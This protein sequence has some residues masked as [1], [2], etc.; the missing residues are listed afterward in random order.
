MIDRKEQPGQG[1][2]NRI[3]KLETPGHG[4]E[5][6]DKAPGEETSQDNIQF[7]QQ[8]FK[9]KKVDRDI[10]KKEDKPLDKQD[11]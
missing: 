1:Q 7:T 8:A 9:G 3:N 10:T 5:G 2:E 4:P 11:L 6:V